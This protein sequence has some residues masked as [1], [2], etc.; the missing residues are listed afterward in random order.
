MLS[1]KIYS[2]RLQGYYTAA[3]Y[4]LYSIVPSNQLLGLQIEGKVLIGQYF[5]NVRLQKG[6]SEN[7]V[8]RLIGP[9]FQAS[10]LWDFESGDDN[11]IDGWSIIEFKK[12]CEILGVNP[13]D[14]ADIP[15]SNLNGLSLSELIKA[16]R[17]EKG[18]SI[19]A[20]SDRIGYESGVIEAIEGD[21]QGIVCIDAIRQLAMALDIP[22]R[23]IL[24]KL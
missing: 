6:L 18:Y 20:L 13:T 11:D 10:L 24:E 3:V 15:T 2:R 8:A 14:F 22:L 17:D 21:R 1:A 9:K 16:R 12:Y 19:E 5:K 4:A 23:V 7:D